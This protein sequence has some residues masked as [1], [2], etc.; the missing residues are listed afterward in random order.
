MS[1]LRQFLNFLRQPLDWPR[2]RKS[3]DGSLCKLA[4]FALGVLTLGHTFAVTT[5]EMLEYRFPWYLFL[6]S[7]LVVFILSSAWLRVHRFRNRWENFAAFILALTVGHWIALDFHHLL[8]HGWHLPK[9]I[10]TLITLFGLVLCTFF[11]HHVR[12]SWRGVVTF[13]RISATERVKRSPI[14]N[15]VI[16]LS[17]PTTVPKI[18]NKI[19]FKKTKTG[20]EWLELSGILADDISRMNDLGFHNWQQPLRA[21][22]PHVENLR[23][24]WIVVSRS[25]NGNTEIAEPKLPGESPDNT[26]GSAPYG[27]IAETIFGRY[28]DLATTEIYISDPVDFE[29]FKTLEHY[30]RSKILDVLPRGSS[31]STAIDITGGMKVSSALGS[32]LTV[33]DE[34][35][36]QYVQTIATDDPK[37]QIYDVRNNIAP[38]TPG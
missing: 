2:L 24:L 23:S 31:R 35:V 38:G 14:H 6:V 29:D 26:L 7:C 34:A 8:A 36:F 19:S 10:I 1:S 27:K 21:I 17:P 16:F 18:A 30:I 37:A 20:D 22:L 11:L 5:W 9:W 12:H 3:V 33:N 25:S 15:L 32:L 4:L 28:L 13:E